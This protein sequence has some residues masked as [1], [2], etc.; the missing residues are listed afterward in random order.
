MGAYE[1]ELYTRQVNEGDVA[2]QTETQYCTD[3]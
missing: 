2:K 1:Q 3:H